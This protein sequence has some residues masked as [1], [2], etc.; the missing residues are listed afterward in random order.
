[1]SASRAYPENLTAS[2]HHKQHSLLW[3]VWI[4]YGLIIA[5]VWT[6]RPL[7]YALFWTTAAWFLSWAV[8]GVG[9]GEA[10]GFTL[11]PLR[12]SAILIGIGVLAAAAVI[13]AGVL[14][15]TIHAPFSIGD[16]IARGSGY[17]IWA[18]LQQWIQQCFFFT[19]FER[20]TGSGRLS[21]FLAAF[22]FALAHLPNPVL[23]PITFLG[24]W[25]LSELFRRYR[26]IVSLGIAHGLVGLA[27]DASVPGHWLHHMRVGL[28][29]LHYHG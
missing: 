3:Q 13:G 29:Y 6:A 7:Q 23:T 11:R 22:L 12:V 9:R 1:M 18:V 15:G 25:V 19:R 2:I 26:T 28:G 24:G 10:A 17:L 20:I 27:I 8:I 4:G 21:A 14:V 16:P 5:T